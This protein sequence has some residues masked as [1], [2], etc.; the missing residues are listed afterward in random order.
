MIYNTTSNNRL[1]Y[2]MESYKERNLYYK[3][4]AGYLFNELIDGYEKRITD[5]LALLRNRESIYYSDRIGADFK[6]IENMQPNLVT[7]D[8]H[9]AQLKNDN[10]ENNDRGESSDILI[11]FDD[12]L[13][14][15][16]CK[17]LTNPTYS[18]D[19]S[20]VQER[21]KFLKTHFRN[22]NVLQV[23]LYKENKW[24]NSDN[25]KRK[26]SFYTN[27]TNG[28]FDI[29]CVVLFWEDLLSKIDNDIVKNYLDVQLRREWKKKRNIL[30]KTN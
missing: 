6:N 10:E 21:L 15:I 27:F 11:W 13:I 18:K 29:P 16:E 9:T 4:F 20:Q 3:I 5:F 14:S 30:S 26:E 28:K 2:E 19:V 8:Y 22:I 7:F 25:T 24:G 17:Y 1:F 23:I 12:L